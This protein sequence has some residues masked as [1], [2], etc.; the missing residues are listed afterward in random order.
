[1]DAKE[2]GAKLKDIRKEKKLTL[3]D[4]K[5]RTG[6]S[7]SYLSQIENGY[8]D[9]PKPPLLKKIAEGLDVSYIYLMNLAGYSDSY[10]GEDDLFKEERFLNKRKNV[11]V[12][13]PC[14]EELISPNGEQSIRELSD[15]E[16]RRRLFDLSD[17]LNLKVDLYYKN[18]YLT[19]EKR[20]KVKLML[21][22]ILE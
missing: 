6:Y 12:K 1:M 22:L 8:K 9:L 4:L 16:L 21:E 5:A 11:N 2:F 10:V 14:T 19:D 3:L 7:D 20:R 13:L 17:L 15:D 18:A